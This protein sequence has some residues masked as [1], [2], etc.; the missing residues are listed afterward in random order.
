MTEKIKIKP[1]PLH[2]YQK[3]ARQF[4]VAHPYAG[5]FLDVGMG[6]SLITLDSL[7]Y[8]KPKRTL[9]IAP[10]QIARSTWVDEIKKW[11]IPL[12][13]K[14]LIVKENG[15]NVTRQERLQNYADVLKSGPCI[16]FLNRD[17]VKDCV[18]YYHD[19]NIPW[20]FKYVIIDECQS[21]KSYKSTRYK[22]LIKVRPQ[23]ERL[24]ELT[25]TPAPNGLLDLWS[26]ISL[27]DLGQALGRSYF[28]YRSR[29]FK[30]VRYINNRPIK[31][32]PI[33]TPNYNAE[34]DIYQR[35]KHLVISMKNTN[36]KL[37]KVTYK[38]DNII[39][40]DDEMQM[41]HNLVREKVLNLT[42]NV[43]ITAANAAVLAS[44]LSQL[45]N[46]AIYIDDEHHFIELHQEKLIRLKYL[47]ENTD[48]PVIVAYHYQSDRI[49]ISQ[50]LKKNKI[51][52]QIF[53]GS[54]KMIHKWNAGKI[55]V[56]LLQP[57]SSGFG[58]NLQD[59]GHTLIWYSLPWSLEQYIQTNGRLARQG[60][61]YPVVI[62]HLVTQKTI[63]NHILD[64]L[65]HKNTTQQNLMRA[66]DQTL[67]ETQNYLKGKHND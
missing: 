66:V 43:Q 34:N 50:Y 63:D 3:Y 2:A 60:Q 28:E 58:L 1:I 55:N 48:S 33:K 24:I 32:E 51:P 27:L 10:K 12:P 40:D 7:L 39:L 14:N 41:Y 16:F 21:F 38:I 64:S 61:K 26:Q 13:Y 52:C 42:D 31:W 23:I 65:H 44:K 30:P 53:D 54:P 4:I 47:I 9:I 67:T 15:K 35:I 22:A 19:R 29:F 20:P 25:G 45:A 46:G 37:P 56:L 17:L 49:L 59:G 8:L 5:L 11:H 57:A 62:H 18:E 36:L 6:K